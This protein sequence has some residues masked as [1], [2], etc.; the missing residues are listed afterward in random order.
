MEPCTSGVGRVAVFGPAVGTES[1]GRSTDQVEK[2]PDNIYDGAFS[3]DVGF[4]GTVPLLATGVVAGAGEQPTAPF[5]ESASF[6]WFL[7]PDDWKQVRGVF[8]HHKFI[9][10]LA[11]DNLADECSSRGST[12]SASSTSKVDYAVD[13]GGEG[14]D[15]IDEEEILYY[16]GSEL[17]DDDEEDDC[18]A[19]DCVEHAWA[20]ACTTSMGREAMTMPTVLEESSTLGADY[21]CDT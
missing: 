16:Q 1:R 19:E 20:R 3:L 10:E 8:T 15:D 21:D 4:P 12:I 5:G 9:A 7:D 14:I 2:D 17:V 13:V 6:Y 18:Y 11:I